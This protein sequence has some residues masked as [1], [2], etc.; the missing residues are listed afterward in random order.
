MPPT[1]I[2]PVK[3]MLRALDL[4]QLSE[5]M[6]GLLASGEPNLRGRLKDYAA[7]RGIEL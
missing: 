5:T 3:L 6:S 4:P 2:G 7:G 1:S